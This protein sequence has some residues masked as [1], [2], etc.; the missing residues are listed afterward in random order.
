MCERGTKDYANCA[1]AWYT[2]RALGCS[3]E[4]SKRL[5]QWRPKADFCHYALVRCN[6]IFFQDIVLDYMNTWKVDVNTKQQK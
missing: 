5:Q 4:V 3:V 6:T 1:K 2:D